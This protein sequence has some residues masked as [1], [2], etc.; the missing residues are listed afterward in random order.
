MLGTCPEPEWML[1]LLVCPVSGG[2]HHLEQVESRLAG[3]RQTLAFS[4]NKDLSRLLVPELKA[5]LLPVLDMYETERGTAYISKDFAVTGRGFSLGGLHIHTLADNPGTPVCVDFS[6][7]LGRM[8]DILQLPDQIGRQVLSHRERIAVS[9]LADIASPLISI[10]SMPPSRIASPDSSAFLADRLSQISDRAEELQFHLS[11][12]M[13]YV[14]NCADLDA[15][16][17][18]GTC[19]SAL[20]AG[21]GLAD[22]PAHQ[23]T[24]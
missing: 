10:A 16:P 22:A 18:D 3:V 8:Q 24:A 17:D 7:A 21:G 14:R 15:L 20:N 12:L 2:R 13:R 11:M 5:D 9:A 1:R 19:K 4:R 23:R 6:F